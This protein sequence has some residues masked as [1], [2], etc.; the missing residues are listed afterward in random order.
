MVIWGENFVYDG[1]IQPF[2]HSDGTTGRN[3]KQG[4]RK[5]LFLYVWPHNHVVRLVQ[6]SLTVSPVNAPQFDSFTGVPSN[7]PSLSASFGSATSS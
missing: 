7:F 6:L 4:I 1:H 2:F 3:R 5:T